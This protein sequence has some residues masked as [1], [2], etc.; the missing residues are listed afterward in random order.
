MIKSLAAIFAASA[1][2]LSSANAAAITFK[3]DWLNAIELGNVAFDCGTLGVDFCTDSAGPGF[4]YL[5][6]G[7]TFNAAAFAGG[8]ATQLIQDISPRNSGL[9]AL[10]E[11]NQNTA[12]TQIEPAEPVSLTFEEEFRLT[13]IEFNSGADRDCSSPGGEGR[14]GFF[15]L[16]IDGLLAGNFEAVDLMTLVFEGMKFDF[17]PTTEG[18]GVAIAELEIIAMPGP[19]ALPLL[20]SGLA[21]HGFVSRRRKLA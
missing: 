15:D 8:V 3:G 14:C 17:V 12:Q 7:F 13:N 18:A 2:A 20:L 11:A 9:G 10:S 1:L 5:T 21:G 16:F 4:N 6:G 19:A